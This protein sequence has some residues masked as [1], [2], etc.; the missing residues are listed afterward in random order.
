MTWKVQRCINCV[1]IQ[2]LLCEFVFQVSV[3][4][5][6]IPA[7]IRFSSH[8]WNT[9][10]WNVL[11]LSTRNRVIIFIIPH[12]IWKWLIM[13]IIFRLSILEFFAPA[14]DFLKTLILWF[15]S[16]IRKRILENSNMIRS[17]L[18]WSH[19]KKLHKK[20]ECLFCNFLNNSLHHIESRIL[21]KI[22]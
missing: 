13:P 20:R 11:I 8:S 6:T 10:P 9:N 21:F 14:R 12:F 3:N 1:R 5:I 22:F 18:L 19:S 7:F 17:A 15:S 4:Y 2:N 16:I